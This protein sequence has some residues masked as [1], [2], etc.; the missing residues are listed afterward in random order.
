MNNTHEVIS[1]L[2]DNESFDPEELLTALSEPAGRALLIDLAALRRIVQ[3]SEAA[4]PIGTVVTAGRR[5]WPLLAA[6]AAVLIALVGG[7]AVGG[8]QT[9][10]TSAGA[11]PPTRI[12]QAMPFTPTGGNQ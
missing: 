11:P 12:V 8:R 2:L 3:P 10:K 9:T 6:A 5:Q 4:P 7:Y 1:A